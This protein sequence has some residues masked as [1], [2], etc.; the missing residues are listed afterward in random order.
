ME[1]E[2]STTCNINEYMTTILL[3]Y[4]QKDQISNMLYMYMVTIKLLAR[5]IVNIYN[6]IFGFM[7]TNN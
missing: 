7:T 4:Q 6:K 5:T 3:Y 2:V 1:Y